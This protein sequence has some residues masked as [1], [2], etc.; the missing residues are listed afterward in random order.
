MEV[1][2]FLPVTVS[3]QVDVFTWLFRLSISMLIP[4]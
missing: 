3:V 4:C 2:G 1:C